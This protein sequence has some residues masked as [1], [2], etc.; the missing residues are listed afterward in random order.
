MDHWEGLPDNVLGL[1]EYPI[2][3]FFGT[4]AVCYL[5]SITPVEQENDKG[6]KVMVGQPITPDHLDNVRKGD[7]VLLGSPFR[8][9]EQP[10]LP[11]E[12]TKWL[13]D[14]GIKLLGVGYPGIAFE[15]DFKAPAPHN[16][17]THRNMLGNNIPVC[18]PLVN[19]EKLKKDR[20]FYIGMPLSVERLEGCW[21]RALAVEEE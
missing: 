14:T 3:T 16:S 17:P 1:W 19:L 5:D 4:A 18:Y 8:G 7:I 10:T 21:V 12:T 11:K 20:A 15:S 6:E 13:A 9:S 2:A